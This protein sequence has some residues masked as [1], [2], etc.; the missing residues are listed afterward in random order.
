[1]MAR[2]VQGAMVLALALGPLA[3]GLGACASDDKGSSTSGK[4][5]TSK[6]AMAPEAILFLP[7]AEQDGRITKQ[8]RDA[9]IDA[10]WQKVSA[11]R[12]VLSLMEL[13]DSLRNVEGGAAGFFSPLEFDPQGSGSVDKAK[14]ARALDIRFAKLDRNDDGVVEPK[15][16]LPLPRNEDL[17]QQQHDEDPFA[18]HS[19]RNGI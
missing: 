5:P 11:G 7:Y 17:Q 13:R 14:F 4:A 12:Q 18:G 8:G 2:T 19:I 3:F 16:R 1:M 9:A 15:E 10:A 6:A